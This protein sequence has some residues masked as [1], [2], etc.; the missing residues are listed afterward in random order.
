MGEGAP[1]KPYLPF[2]AGAHT[3]QPTRTP[4]LPGD[5]SIS[6]NLP[7]E[8]RSDGQKTLSSASHLTIYTLHVLPYR[9]P[10][11]HLLAASDTSGLIQT[12]KAHP[13][14]ITISPSH[15]IIAPL[16]PRIHPPQC[17][18]TPITPP[19]HSILPVMYPFLAYTTQSP[20]FI[21]L[22][23]NKPAL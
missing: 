3:P 15:S 11:I 9:P 16:L 7:M 12:T 18:K 8:Y 1:A 13:L 21:E 19:D 22:P 5:L 4:R 6:P 10:P 2:P 14:H 20:H 23:M 17:F